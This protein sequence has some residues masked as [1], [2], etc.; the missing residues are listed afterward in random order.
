MSWVA[1]RCSFSLR[2]GANH[3][4]VIYFMRSGKSLGLLPAT[5]GGLPPYRENI[6]ALDPPHCDVTKEEQDKREGTRFQ[7][8]VCFQIP[9]GC[10]FSEGTVMSCLGAFLWVMDKWMAALDLS[11]LMPR[12]QRGESN[13]LQ[14][15]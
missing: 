12:W 4:T 5:V 3:E 6:Q 15:P 14:L 8:V 2:K 10:L 13:N 9:E 11:Q 1:R 7:R